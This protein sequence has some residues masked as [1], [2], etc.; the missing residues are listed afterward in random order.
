MAVTF[1]N[2]DCEAE[3]D[4]KT[5]KQEDPEE[6]ENQTIEVEAEVR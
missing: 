3:E 5:V 4:W 6:E 1:D 2:K